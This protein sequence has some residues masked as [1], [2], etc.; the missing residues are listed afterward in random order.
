MPSRIRV[1]FVGLS[2]TGWAATNLAPALFQ[3]SVQTKYQLVAVSTTN[4]A[5]AKAAAEKYATQLGN[6]VKAYHGDSGL[7]AADPDVDL[8]VVSV[9]TPLHK[10]VVLPVIAQKKNFFLEWPA[11]RSLEETLEIQAAAHKQ[12]VKSFIGLQ[13]RNS[14][15]IRKVKQ[16]VQ[17]GAIGAVRSATMI[18]FVSR[19]SNVWPPFVAEGSSY[20]VD[21]A[22]GATALSI[23]VG[24]QLDPFTFVLGDFSTINAT[25]TIIYPTATIVGADGKPTGKTLPATNPDH[26]AISGLLK[27]GALASITWRT[28]YKNTPG[29]KHLLWEIDGEEGSIR[30]ESDDYVFMNVSNPTVYL[31]GEKVEIAGV[32]TGVL[33]ILGAAWDAYADG[34][35]PYATIDDAVKNHRILDAVKRSLKEGKTIVL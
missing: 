28:G 8:V 32:E 3:P 16:L 17:S 4:E 6:D 12:G 27:S 31:N 35:Q 7:I 19:E 13:A 2:T 29:R 26:Y 25:G 18:G 11:G 24:H 23:S 5:S 15:V 20:T 1:G 21:S 10:D 34:D 9:R 33:G 14:H 22:N 30:V